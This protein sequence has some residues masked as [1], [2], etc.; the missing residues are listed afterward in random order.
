MR[1]FDKMKRSD[2]NSYTDCHKFSKILNWKLRRSSLLGRKLDINTIDDDTVATTKKKKRKLRKQPTDSKDIYKYAKEILV[3]AAN[4]VDRKNDWLP[5]QLPWEW[6][7]G[8]AK[9]GTKQSSPL[10]WDFDGTPMGL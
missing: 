1:K 6:S 8:S 9:N 5:C 3:V 10:P 2:Y 4:S 7:H